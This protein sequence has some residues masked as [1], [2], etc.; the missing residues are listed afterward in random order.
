MG[1]RKEE[2]KEH[3]R[4]KKEKSLN[5][6]NELKKRWSEYDEDD[7][8]SK[9]VLK[10][11]EEKKTQ[12]FPQRPKE[13]LEEEDKENTLKSNKKLKEAEDKKNEEKE[14]KNMV[15]KAN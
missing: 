15:K 4:S 2:E 13:K 14:R 9:T 6:Q 3:L 5:H 8:F 10:E 7:E 11:N 1:K 12:I